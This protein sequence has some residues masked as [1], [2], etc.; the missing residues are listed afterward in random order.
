V[1]PV[2][3]GGEKQIDLAARRLDDI[4]EGGNRLS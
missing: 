4:V 1:V 2:L 3:M